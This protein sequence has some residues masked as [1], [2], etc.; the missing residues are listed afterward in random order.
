MCGVETLDGNLAEPGSPPLLGKKGR[1]GVQAGKSHPPT[2]GKKKKGVYL[3]R[4]GEVMWYMAA[5]RIESGPDVFTTKG[6]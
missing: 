1:A 4:Q 2:K 3:K 5:Q 6:N